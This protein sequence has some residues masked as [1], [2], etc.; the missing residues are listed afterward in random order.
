MVEH[1]YKFDTIY[2]DSETYAPYVVGRLILGSGLIV[3][4]IFNKGGLRLVMPDK[5][6]DNGDIIYLSDINPA[7]QEL[8]E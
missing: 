1:N 6:K 5:C 2:E 3:R 4:I 8:K 7:L